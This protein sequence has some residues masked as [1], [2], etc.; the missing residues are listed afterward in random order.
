MSFFRIESRYDQI[1]IDLDT[2]TRDNMARCDALKDMQKLKVLNS[3]V[4]LSLDKE[5]PLSYSWQIHRQKYPEL[6]NYIQCA[7][8]LLYEHAR[9]VSIDIRHYDCAFFFTDMSRAI[10]YHR[11]PGMEKA[12]LCEVEII[13]EYD[14]FL[15]DMQWLERIDEHTAKAS[16]IIETFMHYWAGE[17]TDDPIPELLFR[18][19]YRLVE[20]K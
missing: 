8:E 15:G 1:G 12:Q 17:F 18:G 11:Y 9:P 3:V 2:S 6:D 4:N 7:W 10:E 19:K 14:C 20:V 16:D 5:I 13:E